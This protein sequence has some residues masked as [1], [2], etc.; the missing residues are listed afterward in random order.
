MKRL[1]CIF[2]IAAILILCCACGELGNSSADSEQLTYWYST[3]CMDNM[4]ETIER[5]NRWCGSHSTEEMK[6]KLIEFDDSTAMN[7]KLNVEVMSGNGPDLFSNYMNLP[8]EKLMQNGAFLDLNRLIEND[9]SDDRIDLNN[10]NQTVMD[11][12]VNNGKRYC[13][14]LFYRVDVL[15]GEEKDFK[16]FNMPTEQGFHLTFENMDEVFSDYLREPDGYYVLCKEGWNGSMNADT[17]IFK[18]INSHVDFENRCI[19]FNDDFKAELE[20]LSKLREHSDVSFMELMN[21]P[22]FYTDNPLLF[23][24]FNAYSNP[25]WMERTMGTPT[26]PDDEEN[27]SNPILYTCFEMDE[28]TFSAGIVDAIFVNANTKKDDKVLAFLK[29]LLGEH[30]QNLYAGTSKEYWYG[31]GADCLPVLNSAFENM[32]QDAYNI[33]DDEG[34]PVGKKDTLSP[35]TQALIDYI[36]NINEVF[37]Y[38]NLYLSYY[39]NYVVSPILQEFWDGK[40]SIDKCIENLTSATKIYIEE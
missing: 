36:G 2:L 13:V 17:V 3:Q 40:I 15:I 25:I 37:L 35:V 32:I 29:Y 14:P 20:L 7:E 33:N 38:S 24:G 28:N 22:D 23:D 10:Y 27:A 16:R 4:V 30:L 8:F 12:G 5:Y 34:R 18:L 11:A 31:G 1:L 21:N 6:I 26:D 9:A 39:D 19:L